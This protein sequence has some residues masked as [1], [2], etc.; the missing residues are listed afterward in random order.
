MM[1][2]GFATMFTS[3]D[4]GTKETETEVVEEV[5]MNE[6]GTVD[7]IDT[8]EVEIETNAQGDTVDIDD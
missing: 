6:D 4:N 5:E 7:D 1:L 2:G 8:E 3:C